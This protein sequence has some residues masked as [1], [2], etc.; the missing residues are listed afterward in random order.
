MLCK[1]E[2]SPTAACSSACFWRTKSAFP[3][4]PS[5]SEI[6]FCVKRITSK[7]FN[8]F[9]LRVANIHVYHGH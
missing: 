9:A 8:P 5:M 7:H 4:W 3:L 2:S 6:R 1:G